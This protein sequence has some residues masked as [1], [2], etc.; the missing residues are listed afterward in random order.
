MLRLT[1]ELIMKSMIANSITVAPRGM[2]EKCSTEYHY[3]RSRDK[4]F[5]SESC[6]CVDLDNSGVECT[7]E[8]VADWLHSFASNPKA[9]K[10][11]ADSFGL[12]IVL[13]TQSTPMFK[14][15]GTLTVTRK[16]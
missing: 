10:L 9:Y 3:I 4:I 7:W 2:C 5:L 12:N 13:P 8:D 15:N 1:G 16:E 6:G 14:L 11:V